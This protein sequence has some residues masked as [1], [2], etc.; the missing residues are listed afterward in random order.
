MNLKKHV[1]PFRHINAT[2]M[3]NEVLNIHNK[4]LQNKPLNSNKLI[5]IKRS[6]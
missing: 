1:N 3:N 2:D 4:I 6:K 5:V